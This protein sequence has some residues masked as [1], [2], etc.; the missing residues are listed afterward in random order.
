MAFASLAFNT[1]DMPAEVVA[2]AEPA[3]AVPPRPAAEPEAAMVWPQPQRQTLGAASGYL[4]ARADF[5]FAATDAA[6]GSDVL[7]HGMAR[8][9]AIVFQRPLEPMSWV[10]RCDPNEGQLRWPCPP[11]PVVPSRA[12][13]LRSLNVTIHSADDTLGLETSENYTLT[14]EFPSAVLVADT[15]YGALRGLET[16]AQL[17]QPDHSILEQH[18]TDFPR[19]PFRATMVD[20]SQHW[21]SMPML[22]AH[23]DAMSYNKMNVL[24][25]HLVDMPS[26]PFV[27][28]S[29]PQLS[30]NGA[31]DSK[32]VYTPA[33]IADLVAYAK[34]RGI[35]VIPE[36]DAP[37]H[38]YPSWDPVGVRAG[39]STLLASCP[40]Y[41]FGFLRV[42][43][44]STCVPACL[45]T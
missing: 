20:T 19:F 8:Y 10:G 14:V 37:S 34:A 13:I 11:P 6:A 29:L 17:V 32:H 25:M 21:L 3:R 41:P 36:F 33:M 31:F 4:A 2:A 30:A 35:R 16:F 42:D 9:R 40:S 24:H 28:E 43:L 7:R 45:P 26:F 5:L 15:A 38:T 27:S 18:I 1:D 12:L 39:N 22:R 23:L 44:D